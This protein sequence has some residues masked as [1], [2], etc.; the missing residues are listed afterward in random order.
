MNI[1]QIGCHDGNDHAKALENLGYSCSKD[2]HNL[3]AKRNIPSG[4]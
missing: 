3:T 1:I 2:L 4:V